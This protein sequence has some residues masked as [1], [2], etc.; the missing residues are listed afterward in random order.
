VSVALL[1]IVSNSLLALHLTGQDRG[2]L[3]WTIVTSKLPNHGIH[4]ISC[5]CPDTVGEKRKLPIPGNLLLAYQGALFP[6]R[7]FDCR[8]LQVPYTTDTSETP[9]WARSIYHCTDE[10]LLKPYTVFDGHASSTRRGHT[11]PSP[12]PNMPCRSHPRI[13]SPRSWAPVFGCDLL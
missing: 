12:P 6:V 1:R 5:Q 8:E 13:Y 9:D 3:R 4:R 7:H 10:M 11:M 2:A